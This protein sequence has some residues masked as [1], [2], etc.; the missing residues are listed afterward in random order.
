MAE[1]HGVVR[2][3]P[4]CRADVVVGRISRIADSRNSDI[5]GG[6]A[7]RFVVDRIVANR[8]AMAP[9]RFQK[10]EMNLCFVLCVLCFSRLLDCF[11]TIFKR[12]TDN[13][14]SSTK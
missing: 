14:I 10:D 2:R 13:I 11:L 12:E 3:V 1:R 5:I 9:G 6:R 8:I 4:H 7:R